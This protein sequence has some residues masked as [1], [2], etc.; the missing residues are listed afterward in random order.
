MTRSF[1]HGCM[2]VAMGQAQHV[3]GSTHHTQLIMLILQTLLSTQWHV[4]SAHCAE[5]GRSLCGC[6]CP[7]RLTMGVQGLPTC[8]VSWAMASACMPA[9]TSGGWKRATFLVLH[10]CTARRVGGQEGGGR[11]SY[12][13]SATY[14]LKRGERAG[15]GHGKLTCL[16]SAV[17][18][19]K[20]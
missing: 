1:Q 7:G 16:R 5:A 13:R 10:T 4:W 19:V 2:I 8:R 6:A 18:Q 9:F 3:Q 17:L 15:R 12:F 14:L 11:A 20:T